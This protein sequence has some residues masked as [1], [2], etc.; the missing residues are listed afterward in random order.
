MDFGLSKTFKISE[1]MGFRFDAN[2]F[3]IFN[4]PNFAMPQGNY[5]SPGNFGQSL[6]TF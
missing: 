1:S 5:G 6:S 2:F 3:D 4:H